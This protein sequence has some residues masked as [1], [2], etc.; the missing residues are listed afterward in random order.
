MKKEIIFNLK[1]VLEQKNKTRYWLAKET[2]VFYNTLDGYYKNS[3]RRYEADTILKIC[4]ALDC[5]PGD[6]IKIVTE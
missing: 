2:G 3:I 1:E 6:L 5:E 4:L